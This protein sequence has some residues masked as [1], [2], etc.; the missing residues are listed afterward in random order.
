MKQVKSRV[1][2]EISFSC[3]YEVSWTAADWIWLETKVVWGGGVGQDKRLPARLLAVCSSCMFVNPQIAKMPSPSSFIHSPSS[4]NEVV[5]CMYWIS[6]RSMFF[7]HRTTKKSFAAATGG[8][9]DYLLH[10]GISWGRK[11]V[12]LHL[13]GTSSR[14]FGTGIVYQVDQIMSSLWV[15]DHDALLSVSL[16]SEKQMAFRYERNN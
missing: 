10:H 5:A 14:R 15:S 12:R 9:I 1:G 7:N 11:T 6:C 3:M 8:S 2:A 4:L 13:C 16:P